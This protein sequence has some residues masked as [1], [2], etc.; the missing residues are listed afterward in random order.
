MDCHRLPPIR[1]SD[2][3]S[4]LDR[5]TKLPFTLHLALEIYPQHGCEACN[6]KAELASCSIVD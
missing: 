1:A 2:E 3:P 6:M 5:N 4:Q